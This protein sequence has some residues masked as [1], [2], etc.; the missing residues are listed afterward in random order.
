MLNHCL[1]TTDA[2]L[3]NGQN[4]LGLLVHEDIQKG[5]VA[6]KIYCSSKKR[7]IN[8]HGRDST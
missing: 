4:E 2:S 8:T 3:N 7:E 6:S 5:V 1:S